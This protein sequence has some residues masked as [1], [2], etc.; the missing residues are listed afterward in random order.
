MHLFM[1]II[2]FSNDP[3]IVDTWTMFMWIFCQCA[4]PL[5]VNTE[6]KF[7]LNTTYFQ[8]AGVVPHLF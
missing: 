2:W 8:E 4:V 5:Y 3:L 6:I 1:G 7:G